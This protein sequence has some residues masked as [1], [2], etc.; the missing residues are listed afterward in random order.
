[1]DLPSIALVTPTRNQGGFIRQTIDSVLTQAYPRLEYLVVDAL[2]TDQTIEILNSYGDSFR[3][4]SEADTGQTNA[5]NKGWRMTSGEIIAWLNSD[6]LLSPGALHKVGVFFLENPSVDIAYGDCDYIDENGNFL[7]KYPTQAFDK[8]SLITGTINYIPQPAT[9]IRRRVLQSIGPLN[10][11][12][13][14]VMDYDYWLRAAVLGRKF[15]Y[16]PEL[17]AALRLHSSAKSVA[18]LNKFGEELVTIY[19]NLF[20]QPSLPSELQKQKQKTLAK[21]FFRATD[22]AFWAGD[23]G[24]ARK[25]ALRSWICSPLKPRRLWFYLLLGDKGYRL[26]TRKNANP[27]LITK[28]VS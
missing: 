27:Y 26:F 15:V 21:I 5:I 4:V 9:F 16:V 11:S 10:E 23:I 17:W 28:N 20:Q 18:S 2:S 25:Y 8:L 12:L 24:M 7:Q 22:S 6:D 13:H 14:Y 3:W 1:M 19:E